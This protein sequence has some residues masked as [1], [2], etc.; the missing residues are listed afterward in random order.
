MS[1]MLKS[2]LLGFVFVSA[3]ASAQDAQLERG[4]Y[5]AE[6][7]GKCQDC[8]TVRTATGELDKSKWMKGG[9]LAVQPLKEIKGWHTSAPDL[10]GGGRLF[11]R[12]KDEGMVKFLT[13]AKNPRGNPADPPMPAYT[14]KQDDAEAIVAYLKSLK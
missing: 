12:W 14:L 1:H 11:Q 13:T 7:V 9:D 8:H 4:K 6:E 2:A 3:L 10:T 5:L